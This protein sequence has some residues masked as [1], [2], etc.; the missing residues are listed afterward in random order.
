MSVRV[1]LFA[2]CLGDQFYAEACADTVRLLRHVGAHVAFLA[3]QTCCGQPAFNSGRRAEAERMA[4][5]TLAVLRDAEYVVLPSGSCAG[6]IRCFYPEL[7]GGSDGAAEALAKRTYE[8][9]QFLVHVLGV[10]RLGSGLGSTRVVYH[11]SCHALRELGVRHE[12]IALLQGCGAEVIPWVAAEECCGFGGLFSAKL[13]EVSGGMADRK[14]DTLP[15]ADFVTST[16][17]GC[18]LQ[19]SGRAARRPRQPRFRH[20]ASALWQGVG[21][22]ARR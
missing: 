2:T 17:A 5:H 3:D 19:L 13:P 4:R 15:P 21:K 8:L 11:H 10:E 20:L 9:S 1:A 22:G 14:L 7:L 16:D 18:L 6:M 12:P